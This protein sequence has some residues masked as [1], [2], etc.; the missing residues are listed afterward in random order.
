MFFLFRHPNPK[1]I[2]ILSITATSSTLSITSR[3]RR[4]PLRELLALLLP[5]WRCF[6]MPS[7]N[8]LSHQ[9]LNLSSPSSVAAYAFVVVSATIVAC[10]VRASFSITGF[11]FF[12]KLI[13]EAD[14]CEVWYIWCKKFWDNFVNIIFLLLYDFCEI[15]VLVL[16]VTARYFLYASFFLLLLLVFVES[17][18]HD[19]KKLWITLLFMIYDCFMIYVNLTYILHCDTKS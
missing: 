14:F 4:L 17:D 10:V 1:C 2:R 5:S 8:I 15:D 12:L 19:T 7:L 9:S 18:I 6:I 3:R 11:S 16:Y 13:C